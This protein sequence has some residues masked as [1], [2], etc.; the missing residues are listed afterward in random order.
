MSKFQ[1]CFFAGLLI[2]TAGCDWLNTN[3]T[4]F[5]TIQVSYPNTPKDLSVVDTFFGTPVADPYRWLENSNSPTVRDW[6]AAQQQTTQ[7][8]LKKIPFHHEI[9]NRLQELWNYERYRSPQQAG[10]FY[11]VLKNN[12]LQNQ[13]VL[14]RFRNLQDTTWTVVLDPNRFSKDGTV[15]LGDFSF[16][17]DGS[18]LAYEVSETGSDWRTILL[19]DLTSNRPLLDTIRWVKF[20]NISWFH[21]GF[22]Y[23]RYPAPDPNDV[24]AK[25]IRF[26]QVYYHRVGTPQENDVLVFVDRAHPQRNFSTHITE[27]ERFLI[28]YATEASTGDAL[29]FKDLNTNPIEFTPIVENYNSSFE[30]VGN[31]GNSLLVLTDYKAPKYRLVQINTVRPE[32]RYWE[33]IIPES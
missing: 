27:D 10:D 5:K 13:D 28:L 17:N 18:L 33:E 14:Y 6:I 26:Q 31:I 24:L 2:L 16:S 29:Y 23:S 22:Y 30:V 20:S 19:K 25:Q 21:D 4:S 32:E 11:Y 3:R 1:V 8:Y 12:G 15:A 7:Q 9:I